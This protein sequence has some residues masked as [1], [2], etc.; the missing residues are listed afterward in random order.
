MGKSYQWDKFFQGSL[1]FS[2]VISPISGWRKSLHSLT[3]NLK[4]TTT[5]TMGSLYSGLTLSQTCALAYLALIL[6]F[7]AWFHYYTHFT[8]GKTEVWKLPKVTQLWV[9]EWGF[10]WKNT[11]TVL[12]SKVCTLHHRKI[13]HL[14]PFNWERS[15][16]TLDGA[17]VLH[18]W[19]LEWVGV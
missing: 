15:H 5:K 9:A 8:D 12:G 4:K 11:M 18:R 2:I 6:M 7:R 3:N 1:I 13:L 17:P 16:F 19:P 14:S 10:Q